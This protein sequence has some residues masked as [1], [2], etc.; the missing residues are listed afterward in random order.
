MNTLKERL[1]G[2]VI[3]FSPKGG[4][5]NMSL[6]L[7][8]NKSFFYFRREFNCIKPAEKRAS[9]EVG[10]TEKSSKR[11]KEEVTGHKC[12]MNSQP[13]PE[14]DTSGF[15]G[16]TT[17]SWD[18]AA[19]E[20]AMKAE[21]SLQQQRWKEIIKDWYGEIKQSGVRGLRSVEDVFKHLERQGKSYQTLGIKSFDQEDI[22]ASG[23]IRLLW[24]VSEVVRD[25]NSV[26][27]GVKRKKRES[28]RM[29]R[30]KRARQEETCDD[31]E[32]ILGGIKTLEVGSVIDSLTAALAT[33]V[34]ENPEMVPLPPS[35]DEEEDDLTLKWP[36]KTLESCG[37][38]DDSRRVLDGETNS[39]KPLRRGGVVFTGSSASND[40]SRKAL[41]GE[42][43][44][45]KPLGRGGVVFTVSSASDD[46]SR[47]ALA[48]ETS[49]IKPSRRGEVAFSAINAD[50]DESCGVLNGKNTMYRDL[51]EGGLEG[52]G[53]CASRDDSIKVLEGETSSIKPL[54][55]G[56]A[57]F[58]GDGA[59]DGTFVTGCSAG[60][61]A[62]CEALGRSDVMNQHLEEKERKNKTRVLFIKKSL[63]KTIYEQNCYSLELE[64][65]LESRPDA[66]P[67]S[68]VLQKPPI[69]HGLSQNREKENLETPTPGRKN[70]ETSTPGGNNL[71]RL[72]LPNCQKKQSSG[73]GSTGNKSSEKSA[74]VSGGF[75]TLPQELGQSI[76][77][78]KTGKQ[79]KVFPWLVKTPGKQGVNN[80]MTKNLSP[81]STPKKKH[82]MKKGLIGNR[83]GDLKKDLTQLKIPDMCKYGLESCQDLTVGNAS[84][85]AGSTQKPVLGQAADAAAILENSF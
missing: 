20:E 33:C 61:E 41:D 4:S 25:N 69:S 26:L 1:R 18:Q 76:H 21:E 70:L 83:K 15:T 23:D 71:G 72:P 27:R 57:S 19:F 43:S 85:R 66:L 75:D 2:K 3:T 56:G 17:T 7:F 39:I 54:E 29:N 6:S 67:G 5:E 30:N 8:N 50:K 81:L 55:R 40:D 22:S 13:A 31:L 62:S 65:H 24:T 12:N 35:S 47:K 59:R 60:D 46:D 48:G 84:S 82:R 64:D 44:S 49:S 52:S 16:D 79:V 51:K 38:G 78:S 58:T 74:L 68:P 45:I 32:I 10:V 42:T 34:I 80:F 77:V 28:A 11:R 37:S 9:A 63:I 73:C 53:T 36:R 14:S